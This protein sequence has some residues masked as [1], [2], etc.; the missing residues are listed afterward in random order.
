MDA[1]LNRVK[2]IVCD[3]LKNFLKIGCAALERNSKKKKNDGLGLD[4]EGLM[5]SMLKLE[6]FCFA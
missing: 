1:Y 6:E 2:S 3:S 4:V 5:K